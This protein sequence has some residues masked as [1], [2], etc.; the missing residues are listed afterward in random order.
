MKKSQSKPKASYMAEAEDL[1]DELMAWDESTPEPDM[2]QI[3]EIILVLRKL[4]GER[5]AQIALS[6]SLH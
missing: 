5:M 1:F 6:L 4:I 3:E 2:T